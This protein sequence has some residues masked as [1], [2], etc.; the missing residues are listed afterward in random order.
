MFSFERTIDI[1]SSA[2]VSEPDM[3]GI[4]P[5]LITDQGGHSSDGI[6][7]HFFEADYGFW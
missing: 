1:P 4:E 7:L 5:V 3:I 2:V 6:R